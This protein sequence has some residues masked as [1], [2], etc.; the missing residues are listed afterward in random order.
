MDL[1][2]TAFR[3]AA[4]CH[5]EDVRTVVDHL[6]DSNLFGYDPPGAILPL[7]GDAGHKGYRLS[8]M[9]ENYWAGR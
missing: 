7:G 5:D 8:T 4:G 6:V 1:A 3:I 9:V 2:S